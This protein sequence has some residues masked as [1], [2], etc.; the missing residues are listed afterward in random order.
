MQLRDRAARAA[1]AAGP[2]SDLQA[3]AK[4]ESLELQNAELQVSGR[5]ASLYTHLCLGHAVLS[6]FGERGSLVDMHAGV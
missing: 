2:S 5:V 1:L 6:W 3:Q 4:I